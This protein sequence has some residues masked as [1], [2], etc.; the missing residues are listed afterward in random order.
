MDWIDINERKPPVEQE[1]I[2]LD[3]TGSTKKWIFS[4]RDELLW[5][6]E[7]SMQITLYGSKVTHW[8]PFTPPKK[9]RWHPPL[10]HD[11]WIIT[12]DGSLI[13][14]PYYLTAKSNSDVKNFL[15]VYKTRE[16]AER[17]RD[18]IKAFVTEKIGEV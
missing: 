5:I 13:E 11:C 17:M 7:P 1:V 18:A 4:A 3:S 2:C 9:K 16:D 6:R 12:A 15:G 14:E 8:L 10:C